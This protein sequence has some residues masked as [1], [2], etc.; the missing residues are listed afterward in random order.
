MRHWNLPHTRYADPAAGDVRDVIIEG[1][2]RAH[3]LIVTPAQ[4][5]LMNSSADALDAVV[6][7]YGVKGAIENRLAIPLP[8][9]RIWRR[10]GW[11]AIHA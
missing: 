3:R 11:I 4:A 8:A 5:R 2:V 7:C 1:L 6:C 9:A 10:E